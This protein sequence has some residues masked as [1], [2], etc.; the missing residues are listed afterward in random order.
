MAKS[1]VALRYSFICP[2]AGGNTQF[3]LLLG[4]LMQRDNVSCPKCAGSIDI[5]ESKTNGD[6]SQI[7]RQA[8][9][10]TS[11]NR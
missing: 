6:L 7:F 10:R 1:F 8:A 3:D 4:D 5:R 11:S 2:K 9:H